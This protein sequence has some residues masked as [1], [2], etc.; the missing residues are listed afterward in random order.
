MAERL[1]A[2]V[3]KTVDGETRSGVRI[4]LPPPERSPLVPIP[5]AEQPISKVKRA[6]DSLD[7]F[8]SIRQ[9]DAGIDC[10]RKE[11]SSSLGSRETTEKTYRGQMAAVLQREGSFRRCG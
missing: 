4:P 11:S 5:Y 1:M 6:F 3:L 10:Q 9:R 8:P 7:Q 2:A